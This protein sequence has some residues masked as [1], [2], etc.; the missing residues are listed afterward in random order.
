MPKRPLRWLIPLALSATFAG[1][2]ATP[3]A[4]TRS[5]VPDSEQPR[6]ARTSSQVVLSAYAE[7]LSFHRIGGA[8]GGTSS[9]I[10]NSPLT[11]LDAQGAAQPRLAEE[12][13]SQERGTW[14]VNPD[15]TMVTTWKIRPN[16]LWHDGQPVASKDIVFTFQVSLDP[17]IGT[18][19]QAERAI[20][21]AE[22]VDDKTFQIHWKYTFP[23]AAELSTEA[24]P[25]HILGELYRAGDKGAFQN[26]PFWTSPQ[27]YISNGP[28]RPVEWI[29]GSQV[30]YEAFAHYFLGRP[31]IDRVIVQ[32]TTDPNTLVAYLLAGTIDVSPG[33]ALNQAGWAIVKPEWDKAGRGQVFSIPKHLRATQF[34]LEPS[35]AQQPALRDV[36]TRRALVHALDREAIAEAVSLGASPA[37]DFFMSPAD[38]IFPRV[39]QVAPNYRYDPRRALEFFREV[40]WTVRGDALVD[41]S[42]SQFVVDIL[43]TQMA[44][45]VKEMTVMGD[46]LRQIG[47]SVTQTP[48][49]PSA[50]DATGGNELK[51]K[52]GGLQV[53]GH[54][55]DVPWN[56]PNYYSIQSCPTEERRFR[57]SNRGCW[58]NPQ[59]EQFVTVATTTLDVAERVNASVEALRVLAEDVPIIPMSYNLDNVAV[60][61]GLIGLGPRVSTASDMWD[62]H[63]WRWE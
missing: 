1:A 50:R 4:A 17:E 26:A 11:V 16:A 9:L 30:I 60:R 63:E 52:F 43:T 31:R 15:G 3:S 5:A 29:R 48:V 47:I 38:P 10:A 40:G 39:Q 44:D 61:K 53:T 24:L 62:I 12:L 57:G 58:H 55:I 34:Q 54:A 28:Y 46:Y 21:R 22:A 6:Q 20:D 59:F 14:V 25:E 42:G 2:C 56:L 41:A 37:A 32:L 45:N 13:P 33:L 49:P 23:R 36:R 51:A 27:E 8:L 7:Q 19:G 35:R 18:F